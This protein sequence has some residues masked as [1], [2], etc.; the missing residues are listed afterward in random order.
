MQVSV[1]TVGPQRIEVAPIWPADTAEQRPSRFTMV[2]GELTVYAGISELEALAAAILQ[3]AAKR[4]A[5]IAALKG[6]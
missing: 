4:R 2:F 3:A 6:R 5:E 1:M